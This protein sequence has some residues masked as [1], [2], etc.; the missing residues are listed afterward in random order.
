M[1][2]VVSFVI[3]SGMTIVVA[4]HVPFE[5][6]AAI[7][8]WAYGR[9]H[10][11][12]LCRLWAGDSLP[13]AASIEALVVMGGPMSVW[14][15]ERF[16]WLDDERHI[17]RRL[18]SNER[19]VLGFCLGAQQIAAALG[20]AVYRGQQKE[21][22]FFPVDLESQAWGPLLKGPLP[23][24]ARM[25]VFHWHGDTFDLPDGAVR[26]AS[27]PVTINQ[28]FAFGR[29]TVALQ[30][31]LESTSRSV[32]L[33]TQACRSEIGGGTY[34][35]PAADA[36]TIVL[37]AERRHGGYCRTVLFQLLDNLFWYH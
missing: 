30:F 2:P 24:P 36:R 28:G 6:P 29:S 34:Q 4:Q 16:P 17:I 27:S 20:A 1:F 13:E 26:L 35:M 18:I 37:E 25:P 14:E 3:R 23:A 7:A 22:G 10:R 11:V 32:E 12:E 21:I 19:P 33:L 9:G 5:G 31:H 8:E 15:S